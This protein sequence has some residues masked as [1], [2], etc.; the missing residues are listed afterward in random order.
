MAL[1]PPT[2][3]SYSR[4]RPD[5]PCPHASNTLTCWKP[6]T[7]TPPQVGAKEK[8]VREKERKVAQTV[9]TGFKIESNEPRADAG[10]RGRG[11]GRGEGRGGRFGGDRPAGRGPR[12][13]FG[14]GRGPAA[15]AAPTRGGSGG[16]GGG[17][18]INTDDSAAFPALA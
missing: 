6:L 12:P 2:S 14:R 3:P 11:R 5:S 10:G 18:A 8:K 16:R 17:G 9:E 13:D 15:A 4:V 1:A 7:L